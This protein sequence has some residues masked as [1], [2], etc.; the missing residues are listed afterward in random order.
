MYIELEIQAQAILMY[1]LACDPLLPT[2]VAGRKWQVGTYSMPDLLLKDSLYGLPKQYTLS[3]AVSNSASLAVIAPA[4]LKMSS[5]L[6]RPQPASVPVM[7]QQ[8]VPT[9][10][11]RH[12]Q[13][14][15]ERIQLAEVQYTPHPNV[16]AD[17]LPENEAVYEP[18]IDGDTYDKVITSSPKDID[19]IERNV[20]VSYSKISGSS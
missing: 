11:P 3:V 13:P 15:A 9:V 20:S 2:I 5:S 1:S 12:T 16:S 4:L 10:P 7:K 19:K 14:P 17:P 6:R 18:P 8:P